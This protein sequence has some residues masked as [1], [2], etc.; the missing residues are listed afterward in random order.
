M[1]GRC[2]GQA[3]QSHAGAA[4]EIRGKSAAR[5]GYSGGWHGSSAQGGRRDDERRPRGDGDVAGIRG[6]EVEIFPQRD[7]SNAGKFKTRFKEWDLNDR[8]PADR[9]WLVRRPWRGRAEE[10]RERFTV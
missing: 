9:C 8:A 4:Q 7:K 6:A 1:G 10:R 5:L 2:T 3:A